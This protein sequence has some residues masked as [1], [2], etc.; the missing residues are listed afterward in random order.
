MAGNKSQQA[1]AQ[2]TARKAAQQDRGS[3]KFK[4]NSNKHNGGSRGQSGQPKH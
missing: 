3:N 4:N 1:K 2:S